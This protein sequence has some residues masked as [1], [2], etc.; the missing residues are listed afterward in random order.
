MN[1]LTIPLILA[2]GT[3]GYQASIVPAFSSG[4]SGPYQPVT[5]TRV[6]Y[7]SPHTRVTLVGN[8]GH[9]EGT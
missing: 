1:I 2:L 5:V 4:L 7:H 8:K 6:L 3:S 9:S